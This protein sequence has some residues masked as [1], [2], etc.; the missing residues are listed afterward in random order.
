MELRKSMY[1]P[2]PGFGRIK[3]G[4]NESHSF[5]K[6]TFLPNFKFPKNQSAKRT[7]GELRKVSRKPNSSKLTPRKLTQYRPQSTFY[8]KFSKR[9]TL[10]TTL[11]YLRVPYSSKTIEFYS[12]NEFSKTK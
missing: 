12:A 1:L 11:A 7:H 9:L 2:K 3:S 10:N 5:K 8:Q 6:G 4:V